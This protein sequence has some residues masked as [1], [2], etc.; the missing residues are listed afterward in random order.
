M[1]KGGKSGGGKQAA[2]NRSNSMNPNNPA[3]HAS[4]DN[5]SNQANPNNP[6]YYSSRAGSGGGGPSGGGSPAPP[7][8][9]KARPGCELCENTG[10]HEG[11]HGYFAEG[12][13]Y[14]FDD[15]AADDE[16]DE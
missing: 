8:D 3:H 2:N 14:P 13:F 16:D 15:G 1:G 4:A 12:D 10:P 7:L 5:R 6:A 9:W 11:A